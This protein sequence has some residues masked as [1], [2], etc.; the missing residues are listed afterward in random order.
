MS[1]KLRVVGPNQ[2]GVAVEL[3]RDKWYPEY[4]RSYEDTLVKVGFVCPYDLS[5]GDGSFGWS[6][7][8]KAYVQ[9]CKRTLSIALDHGNSWEHID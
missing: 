8:H 6:G 1:V 3:Y 5:D 4:E 9:V 7:V 2:C